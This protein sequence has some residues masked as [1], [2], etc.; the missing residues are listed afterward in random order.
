MTR[1]SRWLLITASL[2]SALSLVPQAAVAAKSDPVAK[3]KV[4]SV[5]GREALTFQEDGEASDGTRCSGTATSEMSA[6]GA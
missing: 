4:L 6:A 3:F 2:A 5:S 1:G